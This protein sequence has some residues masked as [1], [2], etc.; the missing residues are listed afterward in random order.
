VE[1]ALPLAGLKASGRIAVAL[2][3]APDAGRNGETARAVAALC[4]AHPGPAPVYVDWSE[5]E[6]GRDRVR[7]RSRAYTVALEEGLLGA[8]R[9][10]LGRDAVTLVKAG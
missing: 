3:W 8:L 4:A 1:D 5:D 2:R 7:L 10:T 9:D 6:T